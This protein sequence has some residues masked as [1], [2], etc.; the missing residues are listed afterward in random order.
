MLRHNY[1]LRLQYRL[2][3]SVIRDLNLSDL[4]FAMLSSGSSQQYCHKLADVFA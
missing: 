1:F 3:L 4:E 2:K